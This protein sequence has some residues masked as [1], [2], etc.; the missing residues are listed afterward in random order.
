MYTV[1][2]REPMYY[3]QDIAMAAKIFNVA[4]ED[5]T[6]PSTGWDC[7]NLAMFAGDKALA[8]Q[9]VKNMYKKALELGVQAIAITECGHAYRSA[10]FEGPYMAGYRDGKPPVPVIHS[11]RLFYEYLRDGRIKIDPDKMLKE[12]VTYQDPLQC[13]PK[14]RPLERRQG[15][16]E[17][18]RQRLP[19][20]GHPTANT[21]TAAAEEAALSRWGPSLKKEE[22]NPEE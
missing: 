8:G 6:M 19:R 4:E 5:W 11:V 20:Y 10:L 13:F 15:N 7:T 12:P 1:N 16:H 2:A 3:P 18:H 9:I 21:I 14:R 17:I 22:W